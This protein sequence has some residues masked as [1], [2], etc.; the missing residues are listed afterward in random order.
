M[1]EHDQQPQDANPKPGPETPETPAA[2]GA[3]TSGVKS[4]NLPYT[5]L[6]GGARKYAG[7]E[8]VETKDDPTPT[9]A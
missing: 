8:N 2:P 4:G 3:D 6:D 7:Q 1:G 9:K 5:E